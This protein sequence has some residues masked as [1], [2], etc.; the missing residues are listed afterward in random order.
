MELANTKVKAFRFTSGEEAFDWCRRNEETFSLVIVGPHT[1]DMT[2]KKLSRLIKQ[3]VVMDVIL[4]LESNDSEET[5]KNHTA[6][7]ILLYP[8]ESVIDLVRQYIANYA[9]Y[10]KGVPDAEIIMPEFEQISGLSKGVTLKGYTLINLIESGGMSAVWEA[11]SNINKSER[12]A[13]KFLHSTWLQS[14][15]ISESF[16]H[17]AILLSK[18]SHKNILKLLLSGCWNS[19]QYMILPYVDGMRGDDLFSVIEPARSEVVSFIACELFS[20]LEYIH[21]FADDGLQLNVQ[22][23]D[24]CPDNLLF[25]KS[26][27][28]FLIDFGSARSGLFETG[29]DIRPV[30]ESIAGHHL[31]NAPE[32]L[33]RFHPQHSRQSDVYSAGL[34]LYRLFVPRLYA[35]ENQIY[36]DVG[37]RALYPLPD[38]VPEYYC[39]FFQKTLA[40]APENRPT[41]AHALA[42]IKRHF[43]LLQQDEFKNYLRNFI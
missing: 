12:V 17:E 8:T 33:D 14:A 34:T 31:Y 25:S 22:H 35:D 15:R 32:Q 21:N 19:Y 13:I 9:S 5:V 38:N 40:R 43:P 42:Y 26:G 10:G 11:Y 28:M 36:A 27:S 20:T 2:G 41:A 30:R 6:A 1:D 29:C 4:I 37:S 24:V 39:D 23:R 7:D 18:F 16:N 3:E